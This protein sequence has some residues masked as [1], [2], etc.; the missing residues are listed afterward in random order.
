MRGVSEVAQVKKCRLDACWFCVLAKTKSAPLGR[1]AFGF[2]K[3]L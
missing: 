2:L 1:C 3:K